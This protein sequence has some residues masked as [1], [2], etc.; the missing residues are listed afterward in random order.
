[1]VIRLEQLDGNIA[2]KGGCL[3][4]SDWKLKSIHLREWR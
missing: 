4:Q 1:M 3:A 2:P